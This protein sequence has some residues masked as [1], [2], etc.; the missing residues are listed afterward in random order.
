MDFALAQQLLI[1]LALGMLI[2]LQRERTDRA[3]GGI[4]TFPLITLLGTI[5]AHLSQTFGGWILAA[6]FLSIAILAF[7]G[8][9]PRAHKGQGSGITSEVAALLLYALGAFLVTGA[10]LAVVV[11]GGVVTLLLHWKA[12]LHRFAGAIGD[13]DMRA[14]MQF[15]LI[16]MVILPVLP[17]KSFGPYGV[18][19]P[20][21]T[22][23]MVVLIVG[24]SLAGYVA[25]KFFG[26]HTGLLLSGILGGTISS[27]ATTVSAARHAHDSTAGAAIAS[28]IVMI[29][30]S[31][32]ITRVLVEISVVASGSFTHMAMPIGTMLGAMVVITAASYFFSRRET[33]AMPEYRNPAQLKTALIFACVY[34][35]VKYAAALGK[36][37]FGN[38]GLYVVGVIS[39]L[40]DMDAITLST[41]RMVDG[42]QLEASVGWRTILIAAMSNL[43]FKGGAVAMLGGRAMFI[44][45][46][47]LFGFSLATGG[48]ILW[49]WPS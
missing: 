4:R 5:C 9:L 18:F 27:T 47:I 35:V 31:V 15:V 29:A 49:F 37:H 17:H 40:T 44:R 45:V 33:S 8:N 22:W 21:E 24:M 48:A 13:A 3:I 36:D 10:L 1:S 25:Y 46:A 2:G 26:S 23:L 19:N 20:F 43:V 7:V 16:S 6:G 30:S 11:V 32:S 39:G 12:P 14:I 41:A 42:Q 38:S 34:T 28:I